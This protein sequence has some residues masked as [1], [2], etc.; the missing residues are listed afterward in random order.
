VRDPRAVA[1]PRAQLVGEGYDEIGERFDEWRTRIVGDPRERWLNEL[2]SR[3]WDGARVLDLGCGSGVAETRLLAERYRV[4]GVDVSAA[5]IKRARVNVPTARFV[6]ADFTMLELPPASFEAVCSFY[7]FNHVPRELL[8]VVFERVHEWL[9]PGGYFL[10]SLGASDTSEWTGEWLGTTMFFSGHEPETNRR[11]LEET[12]F[13]RL[14]DEVVTF[15]EPEGEA[16]FHWV[17]ARR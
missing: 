8:P 10:V 5:Q 11:L 7:A 16:T 17:L 15:D 3:L 12:G 1:D 4:T 6:H 13:E 9:R 2:T 14:L